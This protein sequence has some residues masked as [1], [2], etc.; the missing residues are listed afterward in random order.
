MQRKFSP[1]LDV[2]I[3][4]PAVRGRPI[5][6][7]S[8]FERLGCGVFKANGRHGAIK[9]TRSDRLYLVLDGHGV[10]TIDKDRVE[11]ERG[12]VVLVP[13][14]TAYDY[15]GAMRVFLVHSPASLDETDVS[16]EEAPEPDT[17]PRPPDTILDTDLRA[18]LDRPDG[19]SNGD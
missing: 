5:I 17:A 19:S 16:L 7:A 18:M 10:F 1:Q 6:R 14:D 3:G 9:N 15:H 11:V 8:D 2:E 12:D 4:R 13:R